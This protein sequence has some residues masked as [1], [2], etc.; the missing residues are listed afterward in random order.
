MKVIIIV[1]IV[2]IILCAFIV[3]NKTERL[4]P[5]WQLEHCQLLCQNYFSDPKPWYGGEKSAWLDKLQG[6]TDSQDLAGCLRQCE[7]ATWNPPLKDR[8]N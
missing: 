2:F 3:L 8:I 6:S 7:E 4:L 5:P 1:I